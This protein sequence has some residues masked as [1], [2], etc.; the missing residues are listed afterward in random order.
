M[1][2]AAVRTATL[3]KFAGVTDQEHPPVVLVSVDDGVLEQLVHADTTAGNAAALV[4]CAA[5]AS[6]SPLLRTV[7]ASTR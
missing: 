1:L 5:S 2:V 6:P 4:R 3:I 7:R